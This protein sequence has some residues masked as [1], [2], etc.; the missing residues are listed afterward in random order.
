[1]SHKVP[2]HLRLLRGNPGKRPINKNEPQPTKLPLPPKPPDYLCAVAAEEWRRVA[3][4]LFR[5]GCLTPLDTTCLALYCDAVAR[6]KAAVEVQAAEAAGDPE[7][8][9]LLITRSSGDKVAH[10][11]GT[12]ISQAA[13]DIL[14]FGSEF[15]LTPVSRSRIDLPAPKQPGKFDGLLWEPPDDD[16][17]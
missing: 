5:L 6:W 16:R 11:L 15:G 9:G 10:P 17:D 3:P 12:I 4:E 7:T 2:T 8:H 1:M 14:K 13:R